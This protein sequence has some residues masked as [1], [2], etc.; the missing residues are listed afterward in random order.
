LSADKAIKLI[1][2]VVLCGICMAFRND[3][4]ELWLRAVLAALAF[5]LLAWGVAQLF[6]KPR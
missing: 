6:L 2:A 4:T 3:V 5:G 1:A